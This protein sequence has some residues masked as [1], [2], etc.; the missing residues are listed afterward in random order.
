MIRKTQFGVSTE[1]YSLL[2]FSLGQMCADALERGCGVFEIGPDW[3]MRE[4]KGGECVFARAASPT[5]EHRV[6]GSLLGG[7]ETVT[8]HAPFAAVEGMPYLIDGEGRANSFMVTQIKEAI[9]TCAT[10]GAGTVTVHPDTEVLDMPVEEYWT[11]MVEACAELAEHAAAHGV[12]LGAE[13]SYPVVRDAEVMERF[14]HAVGAGNFGLTVDVGH[15]WSGINPGEWGPAPYSRLYDTPEGM[16]YMNKMLFDVVENLF[17]RI[18][19][20]HLHDVTRCAMHHDHR[21]LGSGGM[22]FPRLFGEL[23]RRGFAG[24][25][26]VETQERETS[27]AFMKDFLEE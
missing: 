14:L 15:F 12:R 20:F 21:A 10:F 8:I 3:A 27:L 22:D 16:D 19:H 25:M 7:F 5:D 13:N 11:E 4:A 24:T 26:I 9:D 18:F 23:D 17:D 1:S 6:A 2:E